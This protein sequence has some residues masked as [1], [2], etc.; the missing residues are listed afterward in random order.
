LAAMK[1]E[2]AELKRIAR[3]QVQLGYTVKEASQIVRVGMTELRN[4]IAAPA[5]SALHIR[6]LRIGKKIVIPRSEC[7]RLLKDQAR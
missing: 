2:L 1:I 3:L 4:R 5:H 6:A 7:E